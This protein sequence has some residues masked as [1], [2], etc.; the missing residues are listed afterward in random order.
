MKDKVTKPKVISSMFWKL[1][2]KGGTQAISLV[3]QIVLARLLTPE[4]FGTIAIVLALINIAQVFVQGGL[5]TALIQKKDADTVDFST[6]FY[7]STVIA[8]VFYLILFVTAPIPAALYKNQDL[9]RIIRVLSLMLFPGAL[10]SVQ[11]AFISKNMLFKKQFNISLLSMLIGGLAGI[12]AAYMGLGVWTLVI[13]Y[14]SVQFF[15]ATIMFLV[16]KWRPTSKF[17]FE[18]L[19]VLFSFGGKLLVSDLLNRFYLDFRT[20]IIGKRF[21]ST[22]LGYYNRGESIPRAVMEAINGSIQAVMLPTL[23]SIQDDKEG[24]KRVLRRSLKTSSFLVFPAMAGLTAVAKPLVHL[25]LGEKWLPALPFVQV[26]CLAAAFQMIQTANIQALHALG[27]GDTYLKL[28]AIKKITGLIVFFIC[29]PFGMV[30]IAI[31]FAISAIVD[32]FIHMFSNKTL[33]DYS[34]G[35][36]LRDILPALILSLI[37][38]LAIYLLGFINLVIWQKLMIQ[39]PAGVLIYVALARLFKLESWDYM[40]TAVREIVRNRS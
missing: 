3:V 26:F 18:R 16:I 14:L 17:S 5:N 1:L 9:V 11:N 19:R 12:S 7:S 20:L 34:A 36:Q 6:V 39:V 2:E 8:I 30:A 33:C 10:N 27:R 38:G 28:E 4:D 22:L 29:I 37:M 15:S 21:S 24:L 32:A 40:L 23:A 31:G 25:L 35:E 13:Y